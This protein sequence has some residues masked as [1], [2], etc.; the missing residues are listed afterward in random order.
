MQWQRE[1]LRSEQERLPEK[2]SA[3]LGDNMATKKKK[4]GYAL[5]VLQCLSCNHRW[6]PRVI[7]PEECPRCK[8]RKWKKA[9]TYSN[10]NLQQWEALNDR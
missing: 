8:G 9:G 3:R 2:Q 7:R 10:G 4:S 6:I 5:P 1:K